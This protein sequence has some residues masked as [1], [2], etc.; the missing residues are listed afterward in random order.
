MKETATW[1]SSR[2]IDSDM[3]RKLVVETMKGAC[4][5]T[6]EQN[7]MS[8]EDIWKTL[9]IPGGISE[10]GARIF[11]EK[12]SMKDWSDALDAVTKKMKT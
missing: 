2:G 11:T 6:E 7:H 8:L 9:A 12:E 5:M 10:F 1:T 4:G 3:A